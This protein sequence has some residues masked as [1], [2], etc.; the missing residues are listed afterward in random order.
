MSAPTFIKLPLSWNPARAAPPQPFMPLLSI[1]TVLLS[2]VGF[3][4][5]FTFFLSAADGTP[6]AYRIGGAGLAS[7]LTLLVLAGRKPPTGRWELIFNLLASAGMGFLL[8]KPV[9]RM[10]GFDIAAL[11]EETWA[12][13]SVLLGMAGPALLMAWRKLS[14]RSAPRLMEMA[15]EKLHLPKDESGA[16]EGGNVKRSRRDEDIS[17][18]RRAMTKPE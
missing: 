4:A 11:D 3:I 8:P 18:S 2:L 7:A 17:W 14:T 12:I 9:L 13:A 5:P 10:A 6:A 1:P 16:P 15:A